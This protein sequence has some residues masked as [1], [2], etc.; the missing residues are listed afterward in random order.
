[1]QTRK[2]VLRL[3][4]VSLVLT[5]VVIVAGSVVRMTGSGMGCPDWP[6]C[7]GYLVPPTDEEVL[8][9]KSGHT[10]EEGQMIVR[11]DTL[12]VANASFTTSENFQH[13]DWHKYPKHDYAIFN[14]LH[15]WVEYI[16]RLATVVYGIPVFLLSLFSL[17]LLIREK[18][19]VV[20]LLA[21][22]TDVMVG[23]EAWLGKLVVD[24][25][26]VENSITYHM[27]GSIALVALLSILVFRLSKEEEV[28][29]TKRIFRISIW[30]L[31]VLLFVQILLGT[32]VREEVDVIA[33]ATQDRSTW[34]DLLPS[35]F[36]VHRSSSILILLLAGWIYFKL[37]DSIRVVQYNWAMLMLLLELLVGIVLA[38]LEMPAPMQPLH[39][40][41][42][43]LCFA[44]VFYTALR[45]QFNR[46]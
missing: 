17:L 34:I 15:T 43:V 10:Y 19:W 3:A 45:V 21:F 13:V 37:K 4:Q 30:S 41:L 35:V 44:L 12:W 42:G 29:H 26:L 9:F 20:F 1:M 27:V 8:F 25:N 39:L 11:H 7:F 28:F 46:G 2:I 16:N 24:G 6:K 5:F 32:Q 23:F 18:N 14:V 38:Y 40:L 31:V 22:L 33:K 36:Y